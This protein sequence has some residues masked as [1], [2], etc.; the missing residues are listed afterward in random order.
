MLPHQQPPGSAAAEPEPAA[1]ILGKTRLPSTSALDPMQAEARRRIVMREAIAAK[2][3]HAT[4]LQSLQCVARHQR[5]DQPCSLCLQAVSSVGLA[6]PHAAWLQSLW[7]RQ[8]C[9]SCWSRERA[10]HHHHH[11]QETA[12]L[13][14]RFVGRSDRVDHLVGRAGPATRSSSI[15]PR[16]RRKSRPRLL[17]A[18]RLRLAGRKSAT[19]SSWHRQRHARAVWPVAAPASSRRTTA[20]AR[21]SMSAATGTRTG[22]K[23]RRSFSSAARAP[24]PRPPT[25]P[26][27][28]R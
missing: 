23:R 13:K 27:S 21:R 20:T 12:Q 19:A 24:T 4:W 28:R 22:T 3:P 16:S 25:P 8:G 6:N 14:R 15:S 1:E 11:H 9:S 17:S 10:H 2:E 7:C 5:D 26:S 18:R